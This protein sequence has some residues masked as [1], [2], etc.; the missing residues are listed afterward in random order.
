MGISLVKGNRVGDIQGISSK[1]FI[2]AT[3]IISNERVK[4]YMGTPKG[5]LQ[6][7]W[8]R[9]IMDTYKYVCT[10]YTLRVR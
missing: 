2:S 7:L 8:E 5:I 6:M 4:V 10:Y 3:K 1:T 9:M